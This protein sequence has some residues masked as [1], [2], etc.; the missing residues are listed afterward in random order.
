[1]SPADD[2]G[3]PRDPDT[4]A[5]LTSLAS[6]AFGRGKDADPAVTRA[7]R[8]LAFFTVETL[9]LDLTDPEQRHF[10]DYELL[11]FL[12]TGGMGVVYRAR[13]KS[14]DREVAIKL[15]SAG[16][17]ASQDYIE[18]FQREA[19]SAARLQHPNIVAIHEIGIRDELNYFSMA[20]VQGPNL[21]QLLAEHGVM[22]ARQAAKLVRTI[23]EALHYAH[24]LGMLHLDLKPGNVLTDADG[25]PQVADFG[26]AR[27]IDDPLAFDSDEISGTPSYMAPEQIEMHRHRLGVETDIY[28]L[29]TILY[30]LLSGHPPFS[31]ATPKETMA[32]VLNG[33]LRRLGRYRNDIPSDLEA[34]CLK[35]MCKRPEDRYANAQLLADDLG[36]F[37]DDRPVSVRPLDRWQRIAR[38]S[39]REPK[40]ALTAA[41]A[42]VAMLVGLVTTTW[43]WQRAESGASSARQNLWSQRHETAWRLFEEQRGY[44]ALPLLAANLAEQQATASTQAAERERLRLRVA[45]MQMPALLD[46]I[47]VG[48][49]VHVV[50]LSPDGRYLALGLQP[51]TVALYEVASLRQRWRVQLSLHEPGKDG[52]LRRL[53]FTPDMR[54]LLV[55]EHWNMGQIRPGGFMT[56]R[57]S[58][59]NGQQTRVPDASTIL[60]ESWSDDGRHVVLTD[61]DS[62][63]FRLYAADSWQPLG[64][65]MRADLSSFRPGWLIAPG[66]KFIAMHNGNE[67]ISI[68]DPRT[69]KP[70]HVLRPERP[71]QRFIAWAI[72]PDARWLALGRVNGEML[73][74]DAEGGTQQSLF[75]P[76][77]SQVKWMSF[78]ADGRQLAATNGPDFFVFQIPDGTGIHYLARDTE[79]WGHQYD[80]DGD[81]NDCTALLMEW[82]RVT[83]WSYSGEFD[84]SNGTVM[85]SPEITHHSF[86][87]RFASMVSRRHR[88]LA[89]GAQDGS[90]RVWRLPPSPLLG[91]LAPTQRETPLYFDGHHLVAV[92]GR[93]VE[94]FDA[95]DGKPRSPR[96]VLPQP[97]GFAALSP[98]GRTLVASSGHQ[99]HVFEWRS[100]DLRY[101]PIQ[102]GGSPMDLW[103]A[104]DGRTVVSRWPHPQRM[105][106]HQQRLQAHDLGTGRALGP[107]GDMPVGSVR[108][109]A[110][111]GHLLVSEDSG[112]ALYALANLTRPLR[113]FPAPDT[114]LVVFGAQDPANNELVQ[115]LEGYESGVDNMLKRW[116]MADGRQLQ[117]LP[118]NVRADDLQVRTSDGRVAISGSP[119]GTA[120]TDVAAMIDRDGALTPITLTRHDGLARAQAFSGDGRIL[121]QALG[122]GVML[123]DA[124]TGVPLGPPLRTPLT[125]PDS[126]AQ[127]A[128]SPDARQLV[129]RTTLGRWLHWSLPPEPR[130]A[131][132]V[133]EEARMLAPAPSTVFE[134]PT[135]ALRESLRQR[136]HSQAQAPPPR[137]RPSAWSC[138]P[139][140]GSIPSRLPDTPSWLVDLGSSY[141]APLH[142]VRSSDKSSNPS[143]I[144]DLCALPLG[145]QR[146]R[147]VDYDLRGVVEL[148]FPANDGTDGGDKRRDRTGRVDVAPGRYD[149]AH[150]L[151]A[152]T[153]AASNG[154]NGE[155]VARLSFHYRDGGVASVPFRTAISGWDTGNWRDWP[156]LSLAWYGFLPEVEVEV[157]F[158]AGVQLYSTRVANP[159]PGRD[160]V[161]IDVQVTVPVYDDHGLLVVAITLDPAPSTALADGRRERE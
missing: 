37:L 11:E 128:F 93:S 83:L 81:R 94:V 67:G 30:E 45:Q 85:Q 3:D 58:L 78:S 107:P 1:M 115:F 21:A 104:A 49:A 50:A 106:I 114:S 79:L 87:P 154:V 61:K 103:L 48:A 59:A 144:G 57:L 19:Q 22:P 43:Q 151:G 140:R 155:P 98:D 47:Y 74:V 80:C 159:H 132:L 149:A 95:T 150:V 111:N 72:S 145:V 9:E 31:S 12:G 117:A 92:E 102:L 71:D 158:S 100:G 109:S 23:A 68:L 29:G 137:P 160:V 161:A 51:D 77:A 28:G 146:L 52:Q 110:D 88:L 26:L 8:H 124:D 20:L 147:G 112:T 42:G 139:G 17:W 101:P 126:L 148:H 119:G 4:L 138:L 53:V 33:Q 136:D 15:L 60:S 152:L 34:I 13:Q 46:A 6:L 131:T 54:H 156:D 69:L 36:R 108:F 121:A 82:D 56:Y 99:L 84:L 2:T 91:H 130:S 63:W 73:L 75:P 24:R 76:T 18:R 32:L 142:E 10:G 44:G 41:L 14:L 133:A 70:R 35:C 118:L 27:R 153:A 65:A 105:P 66:L 90:L 141:T 97:A 134:P 89:T 5:A 16:P 135:R 39:R 62:S 113:R 157:A 125:I 55:S 96:M 120:A 7:T 64:P 122:Q 38:W 123:V 40:L 143:G 86:V 116:S 129:A 127:L 25:E